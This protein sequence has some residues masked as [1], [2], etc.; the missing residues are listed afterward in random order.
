LTESL[1]FLGFF[2]FLRIFEDLCGFFRFF[3]GFWGII[4]DFCRFLRIF[5]ENLG[6]RS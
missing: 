2:G 4:Y 1:G 3:E 6:F 5:G